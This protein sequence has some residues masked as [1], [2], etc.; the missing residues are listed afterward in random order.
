MLDFQSER[1]RRTAVLASIAALVLAATG[2]GKEPV[3]T[4]TPSATASSA[5]DAGGSDNGASASGSPSAAA[6]SET[7]ESI[8]PV[9]SKE[10]A[11]QDV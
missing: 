9:I 6:D 8:P 10:E 5:S 2:C 7:H 1:L 11:F 3:E 4:I